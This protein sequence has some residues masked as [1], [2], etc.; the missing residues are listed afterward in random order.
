M[1]AR[2]L[3]R[4]PTEKAKYQK[5][6][7]YP[8]AP[9]PRRPPCWLS[10]TLCPC[11]EKDEPTKTASQFCAEERER[12]AGPKATTSPEKQF[13]LDDPSSLRSSAAAESTFSW[14]FPF[15]SSSSSAPAHSDSSSSRQACRH[16]HPQHWIVTAPS[17]SSSV[18]SLPSRHLVHSLT[19]LPHQTLSTASPRT[20][21]QL[22]LTRQDAGPPSSPAIWPPEGGRRRLVVVVD[23]LAALLP[24]VATCARVLQVQHARHVAHHDRGWYCCM[25]EAAR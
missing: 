17:S 25:E 16:L 24:L 15:F 21:R 1:A 6:I 10:A 9:R 13:R 11:G 5:K 12:V 20:R 8:N 4:W 18:S 14:S 19:S 3:S 22:N 7:K 2:R 23:P